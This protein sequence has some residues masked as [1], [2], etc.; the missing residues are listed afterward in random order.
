MMR[1]NLSLLM[2]IL[3]V[4]VGQ[5]WAFQFTIPNEFKPY[6]EYEMDIPWR[7]G[8]Y[9]NYRSGNWGFTYSWD[10]E[11]EKPSLQ[12]YY[13]IEILYNRWNKTIR[14]PLK[15]GGQSVKTVFGA[16]LDI[17]YSPYVA[18]FD[19]GV[20]GLRISEYE[21]DL[22][23]NSNIKLD[24]TY[25]FGFLNTRTS[26]WKD[27]ELVGANG[28]YV[29]NI[30]GNLSEFE[31]NNTVLRYFHKDNERYYNNHALEW[32]LP[33]FSKRFNLTGVNASYQQ[34]NDFL[35][36]L[37]GNFN[38]IPGV[39]FWEATLRDNSKLDFSTGGIRGGGDRY[40]TRPIEPPLLQHDFLEQ[41][42]FLGRY[43][44]FGPTLFLKLGPT[45]NMIKL[46]YASTARK[47]FY[48]T[49]PLAVGSVPDNP[50]IALGVMTDYQNFKIQNLF[51][52]QLQEEG[53]KN[54]SFYRLGI[55]AE[56]EYPLFNNVKTDFL[57][58]FDIDQNYTSVDEQKIFS[59]AGMRLS[60]KREILGFKNVELSSS[61]MLSL[62]SEDYRNVDPLKYALM[63]KYDAPNGLRFRLQYFSSDD[64]Q[65]QSLDI[66]GIDRYKSYRWYYNDLQ[67]N[68]FRFIIALPY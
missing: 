49:T 54:R 58:D 17:Q 6:Y 25:V 40:I 19:Q 61:I 47:D 5:V 31:F 53:Y 14:G 10:L 30:N 64:F 3:C 7:A 4:S 50:R 43:H 24:G 34:E 35:Y 39:L 23:K 46:D 38:L 22:A 41:M 21:W 60:T 1:K 56:P 11:A 52:R 16:N 29:I 67:A 59:M 32:K 28:D 42:N 13:N 37:S 12:P 9:Y 8:N 51:Y 48:V 2:L 27:P 63:A 33:L 45:T 55:I 68:G 36:E 20:L 57:L 15:E 44:N 66:F 18:T 65:N 62:G 26:L